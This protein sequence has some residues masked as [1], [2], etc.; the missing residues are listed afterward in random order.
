MSALEKAL[1]YSEIEEKYA[2]ELQSLASRI[3]HP[4][5]RAIFAGIAKDS[6]KHSLLYK[7]IAELLARTQPFI[8]VEEL[9]EVSAVIERH[10]ETEAKMLEEAKRLLE[11]TND[12]RVKLLVAAIADDEAE[13]H[14]LLFSVKKRIA[15]LETLTEQV[16]WDM[17]WRDSPWH[18]APGG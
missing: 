16:L 1:E 12:P 2:R 8:S 4:A 14:A 15:E 13:H 11:S 9:R 10:V 18:G 17:V 6:E 7:S 3:K 5:L